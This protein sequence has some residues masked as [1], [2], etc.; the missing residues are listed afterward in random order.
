MLTR[1]QSPLQPDTI[2]SVVPVKLRSAASTPSFFAGGFR[3]PVYHFLQSPRLVETGKQLPFKLLLWRQVNS[4]TVVSVPV[5]GPSAADSWFPG[6]KWDLLLCADVNLNVN[7]NE[8]GEGMYQLQRPTYGG[9][10]GG[11][12]GGRGGS[13]SFRDAK[14]KYFE[15]SNDNRNNNYNYDN[16]NNNYNY[17]EKYYS[18][19]R[20][21]VGSGRGEYRNADTSQNRYSTQQQRSPIPQFYNNVLCLMLSYVV[22]CCLMLSYVVVLH[23]CLMLL[24]CCSR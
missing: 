14:G 3:A 13:R 11:R 2:Q 15:R 18:R 20:D 5:D 9:G 10:G 12:G 17:N 23:C 24:C 16:R 6:Y 21:S 8:E 7:V 1:V 22:L 4:R 19:D